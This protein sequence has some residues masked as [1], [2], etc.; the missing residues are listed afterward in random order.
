MAMRTVSLISFHNAPS[1]CAHFAIFILSAT[2]PKRGTLIHA[3][4][5]PMAGYVL[6]FKQNYSPVLTQQ[7][8]KIFPIG[9]VHS[10]N[11][12]D[13]LG[14]AMMTD[15]TPR[16]NIEVTAS[17]VPTPWISQNFMA[18]VNDVS[19]PFTFL[20]DALI[21]VSFC[22]RAPIKDVKSGQWNMSVT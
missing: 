13:C 10:A 1:Q 16:G 19:K 7:H 20:N 9:Q 22:F 17:Q 11:I 3:V 14:I 4:S 2:D 5:A 15:F 18:P 21:S 12:I 6:E 8:H